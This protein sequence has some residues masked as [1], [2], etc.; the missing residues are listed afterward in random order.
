MRSEQSKM[1]N[2]PFW[3]DSAPIQKFPRLQSNINVDI[4]VVG[5]GIT[6]ITIAYLPKRAGLSSQ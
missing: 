1:R 6:G 2:V 5:A 4:V 3:I